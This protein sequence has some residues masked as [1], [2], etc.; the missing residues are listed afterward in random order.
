M[1]TT[2]TKTR[3]PGE[4]KAIERQGMAGR[5]HKFCIASNHYSKPGICDG[6]DSVAEI[7]SSF[8]HAEANAHL[9]S[10][11]PE[12]YDTLKEIADSVC[13]PVGIRGM[14][15]AALRKAKGES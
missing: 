3:T 1:T 8:E 9:I 12:M 10:A 13:T 14:C 11:A 5:Y 2:A 6:R 4:W 7:V 15:E